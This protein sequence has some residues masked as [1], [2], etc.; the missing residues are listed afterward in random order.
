MRQK[1]IRLL[2]IALLIICIVT[3][4]AGIHFSNKSPVTLADGST[5]YMCVTRTQAIICYLVSTI[6]L[7]GIWV[8]N[9]KKK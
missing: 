7:I 6:S 1:P 8:I 4:V 9:F 5:V 3:G 2:W